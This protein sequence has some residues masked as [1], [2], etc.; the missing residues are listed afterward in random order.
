MLLRTSYM[1][2][3]N[4]GVFARAS[5]SLAVIPRGCP[6]VFEEEIKK[7]LEVD[8]IKTDISGTGLVGAF[9]VMN[10][11][12]VLLPKTVKSEERKAFDKLD[13]N[14]GVC[15]DKFTALGNLVVVNSHGAVVSPGLGKAAREMMAD[16]FDCEVE[17]AKVRAFRTIGSVGAATDKGGV[18]HPSITDDE[19]DWI[20]E[21]LKVPVDVGTVNRGMGFVRTGIIANTKGVMMGSE[22]TGPEITRIEDAL[23]L[24]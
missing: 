1:R 17:S 7:A 3:P 5:D 12:G 23:R 20:G 22:T 4:I 19:L 18:F 24:F 9:I 11:K 14:V 10:N 6:E 21:V 13:I 2:N 8:V 15:Q 16:V